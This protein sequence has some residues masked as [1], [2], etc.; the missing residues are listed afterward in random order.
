MTIAPRLVVVTDTGRA[1]AAQWLAQLRPWLACAEP[2]SVLVQLRDRQLE[3][4]DRLAFGRRLRELTR[5][6]EQHL[7]VND[8]LDLALL[9]D[10]DAVHLP[11]ASMRA[12]DARSFLE[13]HRPGWFISA[14]WHEPTRLP[15]PEVDAL[16]LSPVSAPR[17]GRPELGVSGIRDA[18]LVRAARRHRI[19]ALGGVGAEDAPG[20]LAAGA[21]GVAVIGALFDPHGPL[22][23]LAALGIATSAVG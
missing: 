13:R 3:A 19:Y 18:V 2:G 20:L 17:K 15:E 11:E 5:R 12:R 22:P 8:R 4:Q 10:A 21:D 23:L 1:S 14:A 9:L 16:L 6:H 7:A